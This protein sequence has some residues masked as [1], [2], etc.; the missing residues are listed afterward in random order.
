MEWERPMTLYDESDVQSIKSGGSTVDATQISDLEQPH[1]DGWMSSATSQAIY[2]NVPLVVEAKEAE[3]D[4][5]GDSR[6]NLNRRRDRVPVTE[7]FT[8]SSSSS[9]LQT[10]HRP[11]YGG[12]VTTTHIG[13]GVRFFQQPA[14]IPLSVCSP[15]DEPQT[16]PC[17]AERTK[18][19]GGKLERKRERNRLA[20]Q[21]CRLRKVEQINVLQERVQ[22]LNQTRVELERTVE[23]LRRQVN[24]LH[25]HLRQ[26]VSSGC[27]LFHRRQL[28][29]V[30]G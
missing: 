20:A 21:K 2:P 1:I 22:A 10:I 3:D 27:Q 23:E 19:G 14:F 6:V 7:S 15:K 30:V 26:H 16:V 11:L 24:L 18:T 25:Q 29:T 28:N 17:V 8:S 12:P 4:E 9:S 13:G 5:E